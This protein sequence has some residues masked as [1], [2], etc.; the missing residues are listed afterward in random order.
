MHAGEIREDVN[1]LRLHSC[2][3]TYVRGKFG[4]PKRKVSKK[5]VPLHQLLAEALNQWRKERATGMDKV[6]KRM[7]AREGVEPP[8][9]AFSE[10]R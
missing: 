3:R 10:W 2:D 4:P 5:P 6:L 7:V 8:T 9:P 1:T